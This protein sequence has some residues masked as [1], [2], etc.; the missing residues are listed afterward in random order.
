MSSI[1]VEYRADVNCTHV[2]NSLFYLGGWLRREKG[3]SRVAR[4]FDICYHVLHG[5]RNQAL[6]F[7]AQLPLLVL[8]I[9]IVTLVLSPHAE[10]TRSWHAER[11]A[12]A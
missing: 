8:F 2:Y 3:R 12:K 4:I 5:H 6:I 1:V 11:P 7:V 10:E 9:P